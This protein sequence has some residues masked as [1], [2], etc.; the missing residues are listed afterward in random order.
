MADWRQIQARI[1]KAKHS[2]DASA[3]LSE[4]FQRTRD[5]MVAGAL[6]EISEGET[7]DSDAGTE[8]DT[9]SDSA[10]TAISTEG[11]ADA[12]APG[13]KKRR[14]GRRGGRGRGRRNPTAPPGLPARSFAESPQAPVR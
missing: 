14:R 13:K 7:A 5:A 9:E 3:K 11:A 2:P 1:R 12:G 8:S 10:V 4:L 6:G